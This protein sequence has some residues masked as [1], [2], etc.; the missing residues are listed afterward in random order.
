M[1][2]TRAEDP[3]VGPTSRDS[4]IAAPTSRDP[5]IPEGKSLLPYRRLYR[6]NVLFNV[7]V[8]LTLVIYFS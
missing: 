1:S 4:E 6:S 7:G 2:G 3:M 5:Q 8:L